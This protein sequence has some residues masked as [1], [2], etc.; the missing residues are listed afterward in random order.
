MLL[1]MTTLPLALKNAAAAVGICGD[2][3]NMASTK[4]NRLQKWGHA[5]G[6]TNGCGVCSCSCCCIRQLL[7]LQAC[8]LMQACCAEM[9]PSAACLL[10]SWMHLA[11]WQAGLTVCQVQLQAPV[12]GWLTVPEGNSRQRMVQNAF[13]VVA[14]IGWDSAH[15]VVF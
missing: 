8:C 7:L 1:L 12:V 10:Q 6:D 5:V 14:S 4:F 2:V 11:A 9:Q 3:G 13:A 15:Y